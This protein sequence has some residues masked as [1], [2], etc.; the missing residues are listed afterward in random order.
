[1]TPA[2]PM[3]LS[4]KLSVAFKAAIQLAFHGLPSYLWYQTK[5]RSGLLRWLTPIRADWADGPAYSLQAVLPIPTKDSILEVLGDDLNLLITEADEILGGEVRL[6]GGLPQALVLEPEQAGRHWSAYEHALPDGGDIKCTW[7]VGR[8]GWATVLARAYHVT[9]YDKY[10]AA[11]WRYTE[12]FLEANPPNQGP[13][14]ASAQEVAL[15]LISISFCVSVFAPAKSTTS[16]RLAMLSQSLA[17]HAARIPPSLSYARA[18]NNNH[19]LSEAMGL[20]TAGVLMP[21]HPRS[22]RWRKVG[23]RVFMQ[24]LQRQIDADGAYIQHSANYQRLMLQLALWARVVTPR[25]EKGWPGSQWYKVAKAAGWLHRIM[26]PTNG[27]LPNLGPNDGAYILPLTTRPHA[28]F[29]PVIEAVSRA[30]L[31]YDMIGSG[32]WDELSLWLFAPPIGENKTPPFFEDPLRLEGPQSWGYLR[33]AHFPARPGH[34]DQLHFDLWWRGQNIA[35]DAGTYRYNAPQPWDNS[36][37]VTAVH[38]TVTVNGLD[39]MYRAGRFLWLDWAQAFV[40]EVDET[41]AVAKH[42]GYRSQGVIH[43]RCVESLATGWL[44]TDQVRPEYD[45]A[46]V[47]ARLHWLLPDWPWALGGGRLQLTSPEGDIIALDIQAAG[48]QFTLVRA[49]ERLAGDLD[50]PPILGWYSPTYDYREPALSFMAEVSGPAPLEFSS[51]WEL[52]A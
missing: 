28:D 52:P 46:Q 51:R 4:K 19:L 11:F 10:A 21:D 26:E 9:G 40:T 32:P 50:F 8:F 42:H 20:Y 6:F 48:A 36:L 16:R 30:F 33:A 1:M 18:Q 7:E 12:R 38:N 27:R 5:L 37:M 44:V 43:E 47:T 49:G 34:A 29:R 39:Q 13:H 15:R 23:L 24:G 14:W 22:Q 35:R 31:G 2:N 25:Y 45:S 17:H 41:S 3:S